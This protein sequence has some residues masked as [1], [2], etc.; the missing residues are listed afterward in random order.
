ML[1]IRK[2]NDLGIIP[3][4]ASP[5]MLVKKQSA[6]NL[7]TENFNKLTTDEKLKKMRF[8]LCLN[9]LNEHVEKIP[10]KINK[11]EDTIRQVGSYEYIITSDLTDSLWQRR[12]V[13][14]KLPYLA[15]HSPFKGTYIFM[16]SCQG[17]INQTEGLEELVSVVLHEHIINGECRVH[18]DNIYV[19]GHT[20]KEAIDN[21]ERV[22][23][24]LNS[25]NLK[26]SAKKT[27]CFPQKLDLLGWSKQGKYLVPDPHRQNT[28]LK[29]TL[30]K[31]VK[32]LRSFLGTYR[33]FYKCQKYMAFILCE[34]EQLVSNNSSS[35]TRN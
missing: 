19:M 13:E 4:Y 16:R 7:T 27:Y 8:V 33:T 11:L 2:A 28:L 29:A 9:K 23:Q 32:D 5:A 22:L 35:Q 25:N 26:L 15:F 20:A 34:L 1:Y 31:T 3:K 12:V 14:D 30:P 24:S 21:W 18:A 17:L 6:K 10:A